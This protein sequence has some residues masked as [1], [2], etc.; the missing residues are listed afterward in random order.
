MHID[1]SKEKIVKDY[2]ALTGSE[3]KTYREVYLILREFAH[4]NGRQ[5]RISSYKQID[6][7]NHKKIAELQRKNRKESGREFSK[8]WER[9]KNLQK[10][11]KDVKI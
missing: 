2:N 7:L 1:D 5:S 3:L 4:K 11:K 8:L 10:K 9:C 6:A